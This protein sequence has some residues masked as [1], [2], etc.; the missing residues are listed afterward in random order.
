MWWPNLQDA[1]SWTAVIAQREHVRTTLHDVD[2]S[3]RSK[4]VAD[5]TIGRGSGGGTLSLDAANSELT[6]G[7]A[8]GHDIE[9]YDASLPQYDG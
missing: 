4:T 6:T 3:V 1:V 8:P 7:W 2:M 5:A 9:A